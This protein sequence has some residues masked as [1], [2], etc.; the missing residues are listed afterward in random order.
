MGVDNTFQKN[1]KLYK[2]DANI[3][4]DSALLPQIQGAKDSSLKKC[5]L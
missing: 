2:F 3:G 5:S 1:E 4:N